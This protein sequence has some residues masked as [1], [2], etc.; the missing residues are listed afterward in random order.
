MFTMFVFVVFIKWVFKRYEYI[1][2]SPMYIQKLLG[3]MRGLQIMVRSQ[4]WITPSGWITRPFG[5]AQQ[6]GRW[7]GLYLCL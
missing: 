1:K 7:C 2:V 5:R 3:L 4:Y 6:W